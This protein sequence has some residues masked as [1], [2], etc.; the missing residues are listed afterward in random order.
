MTQNDG[1]NGVLLNFLAG[2]GIGAILGA[3]TAL[4]MAPK[5]GTETREDLKVAADDLRVKANKIAADLST[6][7]D[8]TKNKVQNAVD[9]G[10]QA[11]ARK[12]EDLEETAEE[13][14]A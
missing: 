6:V 11:M 4:L 10:R 13:Q 7:I 8:T 14:G 2:V 1:E 5:S 12:K 3:A 9:T